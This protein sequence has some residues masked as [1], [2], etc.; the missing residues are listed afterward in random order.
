MFDVDGD[1]E[2][3][4]DDESGGDPARRDW[5]GMLMFNFLIAQS[6]LFCLT[7]QKL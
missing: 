4:Y 3:R 2:A 6:F 1:A 5:M 7:L